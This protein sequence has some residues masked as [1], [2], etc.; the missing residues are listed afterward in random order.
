[1]GTVRLG[2][3]VME[4]DG[5]ACVWWRA[6]GAVRVECAG[7]DGRWRRAMR[8]CGRVPESDGQCVWEGGGERC[9]QCVWE[10]AESDGRSACGRMAESDG[11]KCVWEGGGERCAKCVW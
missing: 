1:M 11:R 8:V 5:C 3:R 2:V 4:S 10:V 9:A 6:I 7:D